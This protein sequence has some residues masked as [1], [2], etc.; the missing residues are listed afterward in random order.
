[1][2]S[3]QHLLASLYIFF[4]SWLLA[5]PRPGHMQEAAVQFG[6]VFALE[7]DESHFCVPRASNVC[8]PAVSYWRIFFLA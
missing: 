2:F 3:P 7:A 5:R 4:L 6:A 8:K 1:M